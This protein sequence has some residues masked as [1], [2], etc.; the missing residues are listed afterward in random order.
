MGDVVLS[1]LLRARNLM[2]PGAGDA[3][4]DFYVIGGAGAA[5]RPFTDALKLAHVLREGGFAV[6]HALS[7]EKYGSQASR[8][9]FDSARKSGARAA[10]FFDDGSVITAV[11]LAGRLADAPRCTMSADAAL[12]G[13]AL[14]PL[15]TWFEAL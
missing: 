10:I 9:Q 3:S 15:R 2:P 1:E 14:A 6:D 11:S 4:A 5:A 12:G 13:E 8:N 7:A